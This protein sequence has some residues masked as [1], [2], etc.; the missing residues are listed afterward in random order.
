MYMIDGD[1]HE[2]VLGLMIYMKI[3]QFWLAE[4]SPIDSKQCNF[5][6]S[7]SKFVLSVQ[8]KQIWRPR[9]GELGKN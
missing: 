8:E 9:L 5:L 2:Y 6:L 1:F 7:Q 4:S 3:S